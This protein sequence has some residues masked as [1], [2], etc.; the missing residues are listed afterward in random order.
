MASTK[1]TNTVLLK[2]HIHQLFSEGNAVTR[3]FAA[4]YGINVNI[5][6]GSLLTC[7]PAGTGVATPSTER[8]EFNLRPGTCSTTAAPS[9]AK[10]RAGTGASTTFSPGA[11]PS[12]TRKA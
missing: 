7:G 12:S 10:G 1:G 3:S 2:P 5:S 6:S 8:H 11:D 4:A 9:A